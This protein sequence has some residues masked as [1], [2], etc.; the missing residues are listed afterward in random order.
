MM[1]L[2]PFLS[3]VLINN[4]N[5]KKIDILDILLMFISITYTFYIS[6]IIILFVYNIF[7]NIL[8]IYIN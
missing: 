7:M 2:P 6:Y 3:P 1:Y 4:T 8:K 5:T